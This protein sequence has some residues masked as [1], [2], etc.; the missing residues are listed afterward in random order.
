MRA[1]ITCT[2]SSGDPPVLITWLH[3]GRPLKNGQ[4]QSISI[5]SRGSNRQIQ[6]QSNQD[7]HNSVLSLPFHSNEL[8][9]DVFIENVDEFIST[10]IFRPLHQ[11][12]S[13]MYSCVATN[14][15]SKVNYTVTLSVDGNYRIN[16]FKI[17]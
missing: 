16:N 17:F 14:Q 4:D 10:L 12:H 9:R 6:P 1:S 8:I 2:V 13:G 3:N 15:A 11:E 7:D 5:V